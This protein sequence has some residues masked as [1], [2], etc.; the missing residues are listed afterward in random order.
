[1]PLPT[2]GELLGIWDAGSDHDHTGRALLLLER[3]AGAVSAGTASGPPAGDDLA[4]LPVGARDR[5]LLDLRERLFGPR[6]EAVAPCPACGAQL[7]IAFTVADIRAD[8]SPV[9]RQ[10]TIDIDGYHVTVRLPTSRD[11]AAVA[12]S[13]DLAEAR[14]GL[15]ARC[16]VEVRQPEV[17]AANGSLPDEVGAAVA[18]ALSEADPQ[19]E[20]RLALDCALCG[21]RWETFFD[22]VAYLWA[23]IE[24]VAL[25][26]LREVHTLARAYGWS[27]PAILALSP[28]RRRHYLELVADG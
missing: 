27:E 10:L 2:T 9:A 1:M 5:S 11:L 16:L 12:G 22:I 13:R 23:E 15:L 4:D 20:V 17:T 6:L 18:R 24:Q 19:A 8:P 26:A 21:H 28:R 14:A 7:E 3:V 25:R